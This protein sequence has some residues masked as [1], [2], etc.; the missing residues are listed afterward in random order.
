LQPSIPLDQRRQADLDA[1]DVGDRVERTRRA[2]EGD[3]EV[4]RAA[5][6]AARR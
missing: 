2:F 1:G 5:S 3:A 6:T 4:A